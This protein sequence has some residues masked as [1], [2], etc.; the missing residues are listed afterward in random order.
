MGAQGV[1]VLIQ[2]LSQPGPL[3]DQRL[4]GHLHRGLPAGGVP[5]E[6]QQAGRSEAVHSNGHR[7]VCS[8]VPAQHPAA[9]V[10]G[11]LAQGDQTSASAVPIWLTSVRHRSM[12]RGP[13]A[14]SLD[15]KVPPRRKRNTRKARS[16]SRQ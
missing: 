15:S 12:G 4:M 7:F 13:D 8:Q 9:G 3:A 10:L 2:P 16:G 1:A 11:A 6:G 5:I 14:V